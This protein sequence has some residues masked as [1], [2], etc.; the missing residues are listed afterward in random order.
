MNQN[1]LNTDLSGKVAVVT[2]A[3]G[4][5]CSD[6]AKA[7]ARAGAK[8]AL[9]NRTVSKAQVYA[10]QIVAEGGIAKAYSCNVLVEADCQAAAKSVLEDL[11]PCDILVN[12]AGGNNAKANTDKEFY[13]TGDLNNPAIRTFFDLSTDAMSGVFDLNFLGTIVPTQA[14]VPHMLGREGC[15]IINISSMNAYTPLT[16]I[17]AYSD[18]KAAVSNLTQWLAVHF[19]KQGIRVNAIAPGFF[20]S[21]QNR[22]LLFNEDGTPTERTGRILG[23]TP[24][25]RFG[26]SRELEGALLF[27]VNEKAASFVNGICIPVDGGFS[28]YS[29]V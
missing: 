2:G 12:G 16:K 10:D 13:E 11:G 3:G 9:L 23:G 26:E 8:V 4:V 20:S 19:S 14:F 28:A 22:K 18:A 1:V 17:H 21:E 6:M 15:C 29:G 27:L 24:M 5:L 25:G 7:L